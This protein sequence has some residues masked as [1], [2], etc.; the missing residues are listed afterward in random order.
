MTLLAGLTNQTID[1]ISSVIDDRYGDPAETVEYTNVACR[2]QQRVKLIVGG[3]AEHIRS[4]VQVWLYPDYIAVSNGWK[5]TKDSK[6]YTV[7]L[8]EPRY[9]LA[10]NL[11]HVK[12]Y[13]V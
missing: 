5:L 7:E 8:T 10:G 12:L 13:L 11:D 1:T 9:D 2:W 3:N 6:T 4:V